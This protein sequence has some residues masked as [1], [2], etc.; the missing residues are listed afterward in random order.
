MNITKILS[1]IAGA[2]ALA[3]IGLAVGQAVRVRQMEAMAARE[4]ADSRTYLERLEAR[5][6][7]LESRGSEA[8][9][10]VGA[11]D[12]ATAAGQQRLAEER[13]RQQDLARQRAQE[14]KERAAAMRQF[15]F[16]R[17]VQQE[18]FRQ[19]QAELPARYRPLY[20]RLGLSSD[21]VA[22]F[23]ALMAERYWAYSDVL[24]T[25]GAP[26][27]AF[28]EKI[29][30]AMEQQ[31][32]ASFDERLRAVIGDSGVHQ[33][34]NYE[35]MAP[36]QALIQSLAARLFDTAEPLSAAQA[37]QLLA[38]LAAHGRGD[39]SPSPGE[40]WLRAR[41]FGSESVTIMP[42]TEIE[43]SAAQPKLEG[44]LSPG[45]SAAV[46]AL[47]DQA[48]ARQQ[49]KFLREEFEQQQ[50]LKQDVPPAGAPQ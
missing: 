43:W 32:L 46:E 29:L 50:R 20:R 34:R 17:E 8:P 19:F 25:S 14:A 37:D 16:S 45:Q 26:G 4:R 7:E 39:V 2:I 35:R 42:W 31:V 13:Q 28:A 36:A 47:R 9:A 24:A 12:E 40:P 33:Y 23:E 38:I 3:A 1:G 6:E 49:V 21:E 30:G 48:L 22:R 10:R 11:S 18:R 41:I 27:P 5:I 44:L 15:Q